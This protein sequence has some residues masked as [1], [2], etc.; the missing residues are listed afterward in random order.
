MKRKKVTAALCAACTALSALICPFPQLPDSYTQEYQ[1][2][3][4]SLVY[5]EVSPWGTDVKYCSKID[6]DPVRPE[7]DPD[8]DGL[9]TALDVA[10]FLRELAKTE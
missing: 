7:H 9:I 2:Q 4:G 1:L 6:G 5:T 3:D 8:G 10:A